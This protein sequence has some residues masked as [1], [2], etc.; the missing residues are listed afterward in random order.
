MAGERVEPRMRAQLSVVPVLH[1]L[2]WAAAASRCGLALA[3]DRE[4]AE[5]AFTVLRTPLELCARGAH[6]WPGG[7]AAACHA[8]AEQLGIAR[9]HVHRAADPPATGNRQAWAREVRYARAH[10]LARDG[11]IATGHTATDQVETILYRLASSP[12]RRALLGMRPRDGRLA[13]PLL[14]STRAETTAYC[15]QRDLAWREDASNADPSFARS[16]VRHGLL[17]ELERIHPAAAANVLTCGM[18]A[19]TRHVDEPTGLGGNHGGP[20]SGGGG[21]AMTGPEPLGGNGG[22]MGQ[23]TSERTGMG[24][25]GIDGGEVTKAGA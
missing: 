10:E 2:H 24:G 16:R 12:S 3:D 14:G 18:A 6:A 7:F 5:P 11:D 19:G 15:E 22:G 17:P 13:R 1:R 8:L 23:G 9:L 21:G 20:A 4:A 25:S